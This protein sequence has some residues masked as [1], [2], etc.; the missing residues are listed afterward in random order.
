MTTMSQPTGIP[1][2]TRPRS[3]SGMQPTSDSL[4]IGNYIGALVNW[5]DLQDTYDAFYFV[6]DLH[7]LTV[8]TDP[9]VLR[10]RTRVTAA[11][12]IAAGST[13]SGR[14]SSARAT[15]RSTPSSAGS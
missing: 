2:R 11:Q 10:R 9:A 6:A 1:A 12:F 13:R 5:V 15:C 4:H 8:P 14:R 7:A 3:L